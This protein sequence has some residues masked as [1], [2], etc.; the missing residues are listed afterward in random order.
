MKK[1]GNIE[2]LTSDTKEK[3]KADIFLGNDNKVYV[4]KCD[5]YGVIK[6]YLLEDD[7]NLYQ[8]LT[9]RDNRATVKEHSI[10]LNVSSACNLKCLMCY[11]SANQEDKTLTLC[12]IKKII[13][14][15]KN[16]IILLS[17]KEPTCNPELP[18]I[19]KLCSKH[20]Q[21]SVLT[22]GLKLD[23]Y[24]YLKKLS[25]YGKFKIIFSL[26][27]LD[28]HYYQNTNGKDLV[29]RKMI[30]LDNIKK[31]NIP[32]EISLTLVENMNIEQLN[33]IFM[34][35]INNSE[36]ITGMR[37]RSNSPVGK[38]FK[39]KTYTISQ[40]LNLFAKAS[41]IPR[42]EMIKS[43][44]YIH[45]I[46]GEIYNIDYYKP[47]LCSFTIFLKKG[48]KKLIGNEIDYNNL[49]E[50]VFKKI[51]NKLFKSDSNRPRWENKNYFKLEFR[52]WPNINTIDL[53]ENAK[54]TSYCVSN[55][56][57]IPFCMNNIEEDYKNS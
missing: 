14:P 57:K 52:S 3:T 27:S 24:N 31:L 23:D 35:C 7:Y 50:E 11:A 48:T 29:K 54:C 33:P 49:N 4:K 43:G 25:E 44:K 8:Y 6:E 46:L 53:A 19:I 1:L 45:K 26:N 51:S 32:T 15:I 16:Q 20:N 9:T 47:R 2:S 12:E 40:L 17:G 41:A 18:Q 38:H 21:V 39:S 55:D 56:N 34:F 30:A 42:E 36:Y 5:K 10:H 22:N 37:I 28:D 13:R